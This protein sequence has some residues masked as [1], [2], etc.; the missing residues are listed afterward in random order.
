MIHVQQTFDWGKMY[1]SLKKM[2]V[3]LTGMKI[4]PD[5]TTEHTPSFPFITV[6]PTGSI[7]HEL[8]AN[9]P[10]N[11][12]FTTTLS[13]T[14]HSDSKL[15]ALQTMDDLQANLR[16]EENH[17]QL[18]QQGI[19]IVDVLNPGSRFTALSVGY[20]YDYGFDLNIR[21]GR[22]FTSS[23]PIISDVTNDNGKLN[24]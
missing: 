10:T 22:N 18:Q 1:Q 20:E 19:V 17:Y 16:E 14:V 9:N 24:I 8:N 23:T 2:I 11:E 12:P 13:I 15:V 5:S 3:S 4:I 21:L 6:N 7:T